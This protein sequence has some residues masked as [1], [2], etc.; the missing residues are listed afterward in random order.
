MRVYWSKLI[1]S[2][3]YFYRLSMDNLVTVYLSLFCLQQLAELYT[4]FNFD[5]ERFTVIELLYTGIDFSH[6]LYT[7]LGLL[8]MEVSSFSFCFTVIFLLYT[9]CPSRLQEKL[10]V[11]RAG[12]FPLLARQ[13]LCLLDTFPYSVYSSW[14]NC[15]QNLIL[16]MN[17]LQ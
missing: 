12:S 11:L 14:R 5:D 8:Y 9:E 10:R 13:K 4:D 6:K 3:S 1:G 7:E 2:N 15:I 16:M 17:G